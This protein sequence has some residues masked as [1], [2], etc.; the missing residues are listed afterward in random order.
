MDNGDSADNSNK[1]KLKN[2]TVY[3]LVDHAV[4]SIAFGCG[5]HI[6]HQSSLDTLTDVCCNYLKK[7][8]TLLRDAQDT[9]SWRDP[10]SDFVDSIERVFHQVNI[11]SVANLHQFVVKMEAIKKHHLKQVS[12]SAEQ[13][14]LKNCAPLYA[15]AVSGGK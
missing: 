13:Q 15:A 2:E 9:E 5:Y 10:S 14:D 3:K 11:P 4:G 8:A 7:I 12:S 1:W 6:A